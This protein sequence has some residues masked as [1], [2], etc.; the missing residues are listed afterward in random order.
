MT[1]PCTSARST[2]SPIESN[3]TLATSFS[4]TIASVVRLSVIVRTFRLPRIGR[5]DSRCC[6]LGHRAELFSWRFPLYRPRP[7]SKSA[8][9]DR[10]A[11]DRL[12]KVCRTPRV[13][14]R[15]CETA[16]PCLEVRQPLGRSLSCS[17][18]SRFSSLG[19][20]YG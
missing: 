5:I 20:A 9:E 6:A 16:R 15:R 19:L 13:Q 10:I 2:A 12:E 4:K 8:R 17:F 11:E 7:G 18:V 1:L 3:V 14:L